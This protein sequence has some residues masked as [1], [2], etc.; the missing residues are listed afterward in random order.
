[1]SARATE[2]LVDDMDK[3]V[4]STHKINFWRDVVLNGLRVLRPLIKMNS[5]QSTAWD[6]VFS[7]I[8]GS[9]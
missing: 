8:G 5:E 9:Q 6:I 4:G 3:H 7:M 1:M 2:W